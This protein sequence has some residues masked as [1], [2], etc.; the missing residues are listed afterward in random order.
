VAEP[1]D[2]ATAARGHTPRQYAFSYDFAATRNCSRVFIA[3]Q[4]AC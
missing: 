4:R 3:G 1:G 2:Q